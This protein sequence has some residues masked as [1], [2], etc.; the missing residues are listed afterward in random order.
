MLLCVL[1]ILNFL[2]LHGVQCRKGEVLADKTRMRNS[3]SPHAILSSTWFYPKTG[4]L[5]PH[6]LSLDPMSFKAQ[7]HFIMSSNFYDD[8]VS[9]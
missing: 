1:K 3:P 8:F 7:C 9:E 4:F 5:N 2:L 6:S